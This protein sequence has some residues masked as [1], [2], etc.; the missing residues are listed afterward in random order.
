MTTCIACF[1]GAMRDG[2]DADRDKALR[3]MA[4]QGFINCTIS[5]LRATFRAFGGSCAKWAA[6]TPEALRARQEW[7]AKHTS[8]STESTHDR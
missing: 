8:G 2:A 3:R 6:T 7:A 4:L 5:P 1:H